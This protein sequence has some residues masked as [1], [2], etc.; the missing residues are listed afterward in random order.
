MYVSQISQDEILENCNLNSQASSR[1]CPRK[2]K[3]SGAELETRD[4]AVLLLSM[5]KFQRGII[6]TNAIAG[7]VFITND[8]F[9]LNVHDSKKQDKTSELSKNWSPDSTFTGHKAR[10]KDDPLN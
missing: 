5:Q 6:M 1:T 2:S 9:I 4:L 8:D 10:I 3:F 7:D